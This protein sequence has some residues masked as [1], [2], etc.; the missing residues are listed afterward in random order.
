M[1]K[2]VLLVDD[3]SEFKR[4]T[5]MFLSHEFDVE[6]VENGLE[7]LSLLSRG[8]LPD[9]IVTDLVMPV[10]DGFQFLK[11]LRKSGQYRDIPVIV[12][13][14]V[15]KS[16]EKVKILK[17]GANDYM[18]KPYNPAELIAR[19]ENQLSLCEKVIKIKNDAY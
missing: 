4:L 16:N 15:D 3:I 10:L 5:K 2:K 7:A 6:S 19:I 17:M 9:I 14:G 1:K 18:V 13:S 11:Q 8:Y 12:L